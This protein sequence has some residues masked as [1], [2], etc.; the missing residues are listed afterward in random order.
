MIRFLK[1]LVWHVYTSMLV[2]LVKYI[3]LVNKKL[4]KIY[5]FNSWPLS[6]TAIINSKGVNR[7]GIK[8]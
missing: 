5:C 1:I 6:S 7:E 2:L 3:F 8:I 4:N